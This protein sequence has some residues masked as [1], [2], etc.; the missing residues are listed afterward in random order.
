MTQLRGACVGAGYFSQFHFD[1]WKRIPDV[2]LCAICDVD[3]NRA[4]SACRQW[5]AGRALDNVERM[6]DQEAPDFLDII[7]PPPTHR[8]LVAAAVARNIP[9]IC[10][11][12]LAPTLAEAVEIVDLAE[13][14]GVPLMVH[15]NWRFQ[16]WYRQIRRMLDRGDVGDR[17]HS[18]SMR[19]RMGDGWGEDAYLARQPY[20]RQY[21][22]LL[23][24]ETGVHFIDAFRYLGG[25]I[26]RVFATLRRLNDAI[27]GEDSGM[28]LL[29]F[30]S[31]AT[32]L[33]DANRYNEPNAANPRYTF[34]ELL[35]DASG[36][37]IRLAADGTIT[38]QPLGQPEEESPYDHPDRGFAGDC[39][40]AAFQHF[41]AE[42]RGSK[43]FETSGRQYL[44][45]LAV[46]EAIYQSAA[47]GQAVRCDDGLS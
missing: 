24:Y 17:L 8:E 10:Q 11:K 9:V 36:G 46:Q 37:S 26:S 39:V 18:L 30:A 47:T 32:A 28:V 31:G 42:L 20:F 1:A 35:V 40:H 38:R 15:D 45:T 7:T 19:T 14:A 13:S 34:G 21:P 4:E 25:E 41:A 44:K 12:P 27:A 33:W 22:R 6:L 3:R 5:Q 43:K 29:E 23:I 2:T 16:P